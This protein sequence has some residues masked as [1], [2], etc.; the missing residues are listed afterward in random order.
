MR[1][2]H[3]A[4]SYTIQ[5]FVVW[6]C[7]ELTALELIGF[8]ETV[9]G[10]VFCIV[11]QTASMTAYRPAE[12]HCKRPCGYAQKHVTPMALMG[13]VRVGDDRRNLFDQTK[14]W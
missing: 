13:V 3:T 2:N 9:V 11:R 14:K 7:D 6:P 1:S 8:S 12:P 5:L 4:A 10:Q